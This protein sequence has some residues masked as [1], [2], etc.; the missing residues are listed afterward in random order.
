M[1]RSAGTP[2]CPAVS[3]ERR[4]AGIEPNVLVRF[5][6]ELKRFHFAEVCLNKLAPLDIAHLA[7]V[8]IDSSVDIR[9]RGCRRNENASNL[10]MFYDIPEDLFELIRG[11]VLENLPG[12]N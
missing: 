2:V 1:R 10:Q 9:S 3:Q 8:Q 4:F 12:G 11:N 7:L 5:E 6:C